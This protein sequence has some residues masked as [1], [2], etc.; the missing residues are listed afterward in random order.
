MKRVVFGTKAKKDLK[1]L[2]HDK[3][4]MAALYVVL[5]L[6]MNGDDL[7]E[8]Y[9]MHN[10]TG[11]Y[12]GCLECHIGNDYLLIWRDEAGETLYVLRIGSHSELFD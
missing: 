9:R 10:L 11:N 6:L 7:P 1:R 4:K 2:K 12:E 3:R 8:S 5:D